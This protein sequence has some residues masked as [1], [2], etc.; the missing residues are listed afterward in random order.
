M[1]P[2]RG[3][4]H[5]D[6]RLPV[7]LRLQVLR[8]ATAAEARRLLRFLLMRQ[9]VVPADAAAGRQPLRPPPTLPT[10]M[11]MTSGRICW[12]M[13]WLSVIAIVVTVAMPAVEIRHLAT[14][15]WPR[16]LA[17]T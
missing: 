13:S 1:R 8:H 16:L 9:R 5:A 11:P 3:G 14:P 17:P 15:G 2:R 4:D 10:L 7:P 12:F 6:R